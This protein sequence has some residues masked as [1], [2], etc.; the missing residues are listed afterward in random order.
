MLFYSFNSFGQ[1][2]LPE[3]NIKGDI[4]GDIFFSASL[5]E[6]LDIDKKSIIA[7]SNI[8]IQNGALINYEPL[9]RLSRF[10]DVKELEQIT[11]SA[12]QNQITIKDEKVIIPKM[13][14]ISSAINISISGTHNFN[15]TF[16]Y[17]FRALKGKSK[18]KKR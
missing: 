5:S 1:T 13:D 12:L 7:E 16:E 14:I 2:F 6:K 8:L 18:S 17:R 4:S 11:F 3:K 10:I 15:N 9:K